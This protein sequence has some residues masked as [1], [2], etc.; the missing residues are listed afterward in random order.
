MGCEGNS[1]NFTAAVRATTE[2]V[3][4]SRAYP[5][6]PGSEVDVGGT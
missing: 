3:R 2:T 6:D 5:A 4:S 1:V